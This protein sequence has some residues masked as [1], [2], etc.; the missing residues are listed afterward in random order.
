MAITPALVSELRKK[1]A[2]GPF[3]FLIDLIDGQKNIYRRLTNSFENI[4][5]N[6]NT[7]QSYPFLVILPRNIESFGQQ[8]K[9]LFAN[10]PDQAGLE[11]IRS[12]LDRVER[13]DFKFINK[14]RPADEIFPKAVYFFSNKDSL[15]IDSSKIVLSLSRRILENKS[16]PFR[17]FNSLDHPIL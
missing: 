1:T 6:S 10:F 3:A 11:T 17:K 13:A 16:Y 9:L 5:Q 12:D 2:S 14:A 8:I 7:Y 4:T 15:Q